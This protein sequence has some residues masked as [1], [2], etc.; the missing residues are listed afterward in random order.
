MAGVSSTRT[1][2]LVRLPKRFRGRADIV[3]ALQL[4]GDSIRS[5]FD[6]MFPPAELALLDADG[7]ALGIAVGELLPVKGRSYP[8]LRRL[9]PE[10]LRYRWNEDRWYYQSVIGLIPIT[11][12]DGR[13]V[14]HVPGGRTAPWQ[15]GIWRALGKAYINKEHAAMHSANWESKL[16]NPARVAVSPQGASEPQ[17]DS[18]FRAVMAWGVNTVFGMPAGYDVKIVESNGRGHESFQATIERSEREMIIAWTGQ[19]I[20]TDGGSGFINSDMFKNIRADLIQADGEA[21][22]YTINSQGIPPWVV[23]NFGVEALDESALVAWDTKPPS[24]ANSEA[25]TYTAVAAGLKGMFEALN[26][27]NQMQTDPKKRVMLNVPEVLTRFA[28]P[29]LGDV[30]GDGAPDEAVDVDLLSEDVEFPDEAANDNA[31]SSEAAA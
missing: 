10:W 6:E 26:M 16:A 7:I 14:L 20:T 13:W 24:D 28:M 22:A 23:K 29:I 31:G 12:G 11:P 1:G 15:W 4:G 8:V 5:V 25:A 18:W 19:S 2:G 9:D 30:N 17:K 27:H 21:L 3:R